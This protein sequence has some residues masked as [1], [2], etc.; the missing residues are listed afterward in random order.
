MMSKDIQQAE[1]EPLIRGEKLSDLR[2]RA[3]LWAGFQPPEVLEMESSSEEEAPSEGGKRESK[4]GK[5]G[6]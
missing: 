3:Y 5:Q 6:K 4:E 1:S 2:K